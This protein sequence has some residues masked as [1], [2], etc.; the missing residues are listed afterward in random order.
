MSPGP[1]GVLT[2]KTAAAHGARAGLWLSLG[3]A[4]AIVIWA[5]AALA[6]LSLIFEIAPFLQTALRV[7]GAAFLIYVGC[8]M[9]RHAREPVQDG[10]DLP[11][12]TGARLVKLGVYT[13]LANPKALAYFAAVFTGIMPVDPT[14][15]DAGLILTLIFFIEFGW[16]ATVTIVFSRSAPRRFYVAAKSWLD[17]TFGAVL[18]LL[19]I[20]IALP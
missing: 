1:A 19:G 4:L 14:L 9:W 16:Y 3:L 12:R 15:R 18:A 7:I 11:Q 2:L 8:T 17:R 10:T 6:G 5:G 20:R 13:N